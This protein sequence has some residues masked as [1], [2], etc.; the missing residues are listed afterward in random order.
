MVVSDA[1][2]MRRERRKTFCTKSC[3]TRRH[4][5]QGQKEYVDKKKWC[6]VLT[7]ED[8]AFAA[9]KQM[10]LSCHDKAEEVSWRFRIVGWQHVFFDEM[11]EW[12]DAPHDLA[13][14]PSVRFRHEWQHHAPIYY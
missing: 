2:R 4:C 5:N 14:E 8:K 9:C 10:S 7:E 6:K 12:M 11:I 1:R 3:K 13:H